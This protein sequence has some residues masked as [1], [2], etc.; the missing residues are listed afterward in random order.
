MTSFAP[1]TVP[2]NVQSPD[3]T[4]HVNYTFG[5]V[6]GVDDF[7]Q[8]YAYLSGRDQWLTRDLLGYGTV[9]GL[10]VTVEPI[11][12]GEDAGSNQVVVTPGVAV[13]PRGQMIRLPT[14]HC[15]DLKKWLAL[16]ETQKAFYE[17]AG[18]SPTNVVLQVLLRYN[19]CLTAKV[20]I[21]GKPC[22]TQDDAM[23]DS[24]VV[25]NFA[26]EL[27]LAA[28]Q[29]MLP[30][31]KDEDAVRE[32]A[33]L[34]AQIQLTDD[35]FLMMNP[36]KFSEAIRSSVPEL[37][38]LLEMSSNLSLASPPDFT[39]GSPPVPLYIPA[40]QAGEY[41]RT[42]LRI[43]VTE[44]RPQLQGKT[45]SLGDGVIP[46]EEYVLLADIHLPVIKNSSDTW[47]MDTTGTISVDD[48]RRPYLVHL[49]MLQELL[50][51][52][53]SALSNADK[54]VV[55]TSEQGNYTI[56][57][58]GI[59]S[60]VGTKAGSPVYNEGLRVIPK[61]TQDD[62][63]L[64]IYFN[65]YMPPDGTFQY[66]VK[67]LPVSSTTAVIVNL[68]PDSF[69]AAGVVLRVMDNKGDVIKDAALTTLEFMIEVSRYSKSV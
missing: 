64:T 14:E 69:R 41:L 49:R 16:E 20:P 2:L 63:L 7:K 21:S 12:K 62:G 29:P 43:W 47:V 30:D 55:H 39:Y 23:A 53:Y 37:K 31:Q 50:L 5:M 67:V 58:A 44:V 19:D 24:R 32:F 65:G 3:P 15:A 11:E 18:P 66:I 1:L 46:Q 59:I 10:K 52:S 6:L 33:A 13:N 26:L 8:E 51:T 25:D 48:T 35:P 4:Q 42:A 54:A 57:A 68:D 40:D 22:R 28:A 60:G 17:H 45:M 27:R 61:Q 38:A 34:L 56:V 9:Y 36:D